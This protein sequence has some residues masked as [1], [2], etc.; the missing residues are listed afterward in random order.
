MIEPCRKRKQ[1]K[2][3]AE[4]WFVRDACVGITFSLLFNRDGIGI[5]F[6]PGVRSRF[7][8][9]KYGMDFSRESS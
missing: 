9:S 1:R 5:V 8:N 2:R 4:G 3:K 6:S 7:N